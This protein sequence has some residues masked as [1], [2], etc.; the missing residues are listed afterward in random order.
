MSELS[1]R[2]SFL[3]ASVFLFLKNGAADQLEMVSILD[4]LAAPAG[5]NCGVGEVPVLKWN[6]I[7]IDHSCLLCFQNTK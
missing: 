2:D 6:N 5:K 3:I 4:C 7:T 1:V